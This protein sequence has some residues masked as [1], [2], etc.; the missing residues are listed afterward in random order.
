M[1]QIVILRPG[2]ETFNLFNRS[3][4]RTVKKAEQSKNL[5]GD[6]VVNITVS[7]TRRI[8][9]FLGD[10]INVFGS[11]Y[12]LNVVPVAKK[13]SE[14]RFEYDL[15]FESVQYNLLRVQY[16]NRDISGYG[17]ET[18]FSLTGEIDIF[19]DV[20]INNLSRES[21]A[22]WVKGEVPT[23]ETKTL[24]FSSFNCLAA[25]QDICEKFSQEFEIIES[26]TG[27]NTINIKK[28]GQI[29]GHVYEYGRSGG[30]YTLERQPLK[31]KNFI[32]RLYP[33][34]STKNLGSNY[35]NYSQRLKIEDPGY[36][37]DLA[38]I[39]AFGLVE[40][41]VIFEDVYPHREGVVTEVVVGDILSFVDSTMNFDLNEKDGE[42]T[43]YLVS[44]TSAKIKFN[45]GGL[46]GYEFELEKYDHITKKFTL[47]AQKDARG[48]EFPSDTLAFKINPNDK[49]VITD[50]V[51]PPVYV[52]TAEGDLMTKAQLHLDENKA[53][54]TQ[55]ALEVS[56]MYLTSYLGASETDI[57]NI[58]NIG[59]YIPIK[60]LD[61]GFDG[62][63]R[64]VSFTR[65]VLDPY[66][67][68]LTIA[69]TYTISLRD[70]LIAQNIEINNIIRINDL[71]NP[72]R[73]R[74]S[75]RNTQELLTMIFDQDGYFQDGKIR[76][77]TIEAIL[78]AI[79]AKSQQLTL[80]NVVIEPNFQ[81]DK[82]V[83]RVTGGQLIHFTID[84][85]PRTWTIAS[86]TTAIGDNGY[87]YIYAKCRKGVYAEASILFS[88][89]QFK[90]EEANFYYFL[91]GS[92]YSVDSTGLF[93][94]IEMSYGFTKIHGRWI[95]TGRIQSQDGLTYFD[96]D[97]GIFNG[98]FKFR[99]VDGSSK[100]IRELNNEFQHFIDATL[101]EL[102]EGLEN[103]ID[104][105]VETWFFEGAPTLANQPAVT[106]TTNEIK[107]EH[108]NDLYYNTVNYKTYRFKKVSGVY[109]WEEV[110][111]ERIGIAMAAAAA[112]QDTAD[113]KRRVFV[114]TPAAPYEVGDL[115][116][117]GADL[118]RCQTAKTTGQS[119]NIN[120]WIFATAYDNTETRINAGIVVTGTVLLAGPGGSI[121]AGITGEGT[122]DS[123]IRYFAGAAPENK[124]Y[125]PFRVNQGGEGF[126]RKRLEL[127]NQYNIGQAGICGINSS[128]DGTVTFWSGTAYENRVNANFQVH[129]DGRFI[130]KAGEIGGWTISTSGISNTNGS[131]FIIAASGVGEN[132]TKAIIGANAVSSASGLNAAALFSSK[133]A[134][135]NN[136]GAIF[137]ASGGITNFAF[138]ALTG[139]AL[140]NE[141]LIN[142]TATYTAT[143]NGLTDY[144]DP[145]LYDTIAIFGNMSGGFTPSV[146]LL[147]TTARP[148]YS[149]KEIT[150]MQ[151][152]D[153]VNLVLANTIRNRSS[154]TLSGGTVMTIKYI[155]G[156]WYIKSSFDNNY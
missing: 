28:V 156:F 138:Q 83:V 18:D 103:Q 125:A 21:S 61:L 101:P 17:S 146:Q 47:I 117:N 93:R 50:I 57:E 116:V 76:A 108:I 135:G 19:I 14:S 131:A 32:N 60:D 98:I 122:S 150:I 68:T 113:G 79:G 80:R 51:M 12:Y 33:F 37:E 63:S 145:S 41:T 99:N 136:I 82:N 74:Q 144:V 8:E 106:W 127:M 102:L 105:K 123:S 77:T 4:L 140:I 114:A 126:F 75:W 147:T 65:N 45:S 151:Q 104:G 25:L 96:L 5:L 107:D 38:S 67:Y 121:K 91:I 15:T 78:L 62:S 92:L 22:I 34:G 148:I 6:D 10:K 81:S 64:I 137:E 154:V 52:T 112:A 111:D 46:A 142:G 27:A 143:N 31:E 70:R 20:L 59:D 120:D 42:N 84:D 86:G 97:E 11:S 87:R 58:F 36:I 53:P 7:S 100:D 128:A 49:Y 119:Y 130:S 24:T 44:G 94:Q 115:W 152:N 69:D 95:S 16:F 9:F 13:N 118:R 90:T 88:T 73:A 39:A 3:P 139:R 72:E 23:S 155:N 109:S 35:R 89:V 55:Y 26:G 43:K 129:L 134:F 85:V 141:S 66:A 54:R 132:V 29:L 48:M 56:K 133:I 110:L 40:G 30:L 71:R 1:E 124:D 149:G 2:G 153:A